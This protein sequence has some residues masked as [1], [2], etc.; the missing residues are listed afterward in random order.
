MSYKKVKVLSLPKAQFGTYINNQPRTIEVDSEDDPRIQA[1]KDSATIALATN[2]MIQHLQSM[3]N[4]NAWLQYS[5]NWYNKHGAN[6]PF[7]RA[8]SRLTKLNK[9]KPTPAWKVHSLLP[10]GG[11][12]PQTA[13]QYMPPQTHV[14]VRPPAPKMIEPAL[15]PVPSIPIAP[16]LQNIPSIEYSGPRK[17][18]VIVNTPQG[19]MVRVQ[20]LN[21]KQFLNWEDLTGMPLDFEEYKP[22]GNAA[23]DFPEMRRIKTPAFANGG[24]ISVP[25]LRRV[26]IDSLP[27]AQFGIDW[28]GISNLELARRAKAAGWDTV[29]QY[30]NAKWAYNTTPAGT[31][32]ADLPKFPTRVGPTK[33]A[34]VLDANQKEQMKKFAEE[35]PN[36]GSYPNDPAGLPSVPIF[37][38]A[39]M[40]P[41]A[42]STLGTAAT[43]LGETTAA[44]EAIPEVAGALRAKGAY[45]IGNKVIP[46][47]IKSFKDYN[48]TGNIDQLSTGLGNI[49]STGIKG[50]SSFGPWQA[51]AKQI[52]KYYGFGSNA[53]DTASA[54][55]AEGFIK[56][57]YNTFIG[58]KGLKAKKAY[59]GDISVPSLQYAQAGLIVENNGVDWEAVKNPEL[60]A[61]ARAMGHNSI[62]EYR[63]SNWGYGK[64]IQQAPG[65]GAAI[66]IG[67]DT[68]LPKPIK[69]KSPKPITAMPL[70]VQMDTRSG[71]PPLDRIFT[72]DRPEQS[73]V[74]QFLGNPNAKAAP[75]NYEEQVNEWLGKPMDKA[76]DAAERASE[77]GSDPVDNFRHPVA[78]MYTQQA[79]KDKVGIPIIGDALGFLGAN[80]MGIGHE[81]GTIFRDDRPWDVK[82]R[83]AGEDIFNN[84]VGTFVGLLPGTQGDKENILYNLSAGNW[85]PDGVVWDGNQSMY[86]KDENGNV[87]RTAP[88]EMW[89]RIMGK[90]QGGAVKRVKIKSLPNNWK[91]K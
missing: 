46:E 40:A 77:S 21:T 48:R 5:N 15:L 41:V 59:G 57:G 34:A 69:L 79:I 81:A 58:G 13:V 64:N 91:T 50:F 49:A 28:E 36:R 23:Q 45:D 78:G 61:K 86:F 19:D 32:K 65:R 4:A 10:G 68:Q 84:S 22:T 26:K 51:G 2:N 12:F 76:Y 31:P 85:L 33:E 24:D 35:H 43:T 42:L 67:L 62:A 11:G 27:K 66:G 44:F 72:V 56:S 8:F 3:P 54:E 53:Y 1:E 88:S 9:Q 47:T 39:F 29:E 6:S 37:E 74:G 89:N 75:L 16:Q 60:A 14:V 83:E 87:S 17:Q 55:D 71:M 82:L 80:A 90:K 38:A 18:R 30:R 7:A 63:N 52:G 20:D 25:D 70:S 73:G